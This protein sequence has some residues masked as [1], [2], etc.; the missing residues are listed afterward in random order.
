MDIDYKSFFNNNNIKDIE[1]ENC[2]FSNFKILELK[3][4]EAIQKIQNNQKASEKL[5]ST[6][7]NF[8]D[9][10][11]TYKI[12]MKTIKEIVLKN[13]FV[14]DFGFLINSIEF[15]NNNKNDIIKHLE[16]AK[17]ITNFFVNLL[18]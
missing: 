3:S 10:E 12:D 6:F 2:L 14:E 9:E 4:E 8:Y 11:K 17:I 5:N 16:K 1:L 15:L 13:N 18:F 7:L